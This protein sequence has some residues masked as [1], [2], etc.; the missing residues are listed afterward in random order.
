MHKFIS[1][2]ET[3]SS[4]M[5]LQPIIFKFPFLCEPY[6][7]L[8]FFQCFHIVEKA[9]ASIPVNSVLTLFFF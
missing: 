7:I 1:F 4:L 2:T 6:V 9:F 3:C 5:T 8:W